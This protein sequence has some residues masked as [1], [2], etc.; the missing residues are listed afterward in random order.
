MLAAIEL[1]RVG[2]LMVISCDAKMIRP[3]TQ[4]DYVGGNV[5]ETSPMRTLSAVGFIDKIVVEKNFLSWG[6]GQY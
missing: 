2:V 5:N 4:I 6:G 3:D 1:G